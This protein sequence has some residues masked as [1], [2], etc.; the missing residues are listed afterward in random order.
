MH[1]FKTI[2]K[3]PAAL[4]ANLDTLGY[5][6]MTEIQAETI[7]VALS[8][9]DLI[10]QAKTGS[11]KT[12]AFGIPLILKIDTEIRDP[13]ALIITPTRELA[14]QV[15]RELRRLARY[16][17]NLKITTL[18]GGV[19]MRGQISS[20]QKG[21]HIVVGTPGRLQD[22]L[23]RDT[24][25]LYGVRTLVLDEAD[26]M[27]EMG[28]YEAISKI[29][30]NLPRQHQSLL[31]SATFPEEILQ[32]SR[33][34]LKA[35]ER[36]A[37]AAAHAPEVIE[38]TA[39]EVASASKP[40][41]LLRI[42]RAEKPDSVL[43]FC[44]RKT[45]TET[46]AEALHAQGFAADVLH[47]DMDQRGRDEALLM[48]ANG[49]TRVLVAT[50]VASR[51]LDIPR[52]GLVVNYDLPYDP[53]IY[54]HRIG[55]TGRAGARGRAITLLTPAEVSKRAE[56]APQAEQQ[57]LVA[58]RPDRGFVMQSAW[59]TLCIDGGKK[60]KLRA[61]DILGTLCK[62]I[63]LSM[64]QVGKITIQERHAYVAIARTVAQQAY[65][66]LQQGRIKKR[67]FRVWWL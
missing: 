63:G 34:I 44:N 15:G 4:I 32:L 33:H 56:I 47:G 22:H 62:E 9:R 65:R 17:E 24:L 7:P 59:A 50:D 28:F 40:E 5:E 31:F 57:P 1:P 48:F 52:I 19:P 45:E 61:G 16:R 38:Q 36:I 23:S 54:T 13:Q 49:T 11:G 12:A 2:P 3:L 35:P 58:L 39:Y 27:L 51:G 21:A 42:L 43:L 8:G 10:A 18:T 14:D 67:K 64:E 46:V 29:T 37:V 53:E 66:G 30:S 25:P 55:R 41:A 60:D 20:L 26:R 6:T